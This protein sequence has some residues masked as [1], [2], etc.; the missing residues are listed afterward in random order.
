[1]STKQAALP[2]A[3]QQYVE[4]VLEGLSQPQKRLPG[5]YLWD[6]TGSDL[7][8]RICSTA[9]Y[10]PTRREMALLERHAAEVAS[11]VGPGANIVEY[12]SG[13]ARKIRVL[14]DAM[15]A[16][17]RYVAIDISRDYLVTAIEPIVKDYPNLQ[18]IPVFADYTAPITLPVDLSDGPVLGFFPGSTIGNFSPAGVVAFLSR[19][20]ETLGAG[21]FLVGTDPNRDEASLRRAYAGAD[22]LMAALHKNMLAHINNE[23]GSDFDLDNFRHDVRVLQDPPRVEAHLFALGDAAYTVDGERVALKAG[24]SIFTDVSYKYDP[25]TFRSLAR[26]GGWDPVRSWLDPQGLFSLYLLHTDG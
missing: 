25:D 26:D 24:E 2:L 14:L 21:W 15:D 18:V 17:H 6:E 22:G 7:F 23:L 19:V 3:R 10:Y 1:M 9:D 11:V 13:A 8:D 12:G 5:K 16:P 20:R 4:D